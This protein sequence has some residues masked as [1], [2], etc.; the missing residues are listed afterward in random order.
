MIAGLS[1]CNALSFGDPRVIVA[2]VAY[3]ES[4]IASTSVKRFS[5]AATIVV[6]D[7]NPRKVDPLLLE[8]MLAW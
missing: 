2:V 3:S 8:R 5:G 4:S 6:C 1:F 7:T